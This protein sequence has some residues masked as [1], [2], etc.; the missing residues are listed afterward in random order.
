MYGLNIIKKSKLETPRD[1]DKSNIFFD[2][3]VL[4]LNRMF[5]ISGVGNARPVI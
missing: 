5:D 3:R 1:L 4:S 2:H